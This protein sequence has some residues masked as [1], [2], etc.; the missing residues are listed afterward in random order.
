MQAKIPL[1][2]GAKQDSETCQLDMNGRHRSSCLFAGTKLLHSSNDKLMSDV[3]S[4]KNLP[5][6]PRIQGKIPALFLT[7]SSGYYSSRGSIIQSL[8]KSKTDIG[9]IL[10]LESQLDQIRLIGVLSLF[11]AGACMYLLC[12]S[13]SDSLFKQIVQV[14]KFASSLPLSQC[15]IPHFAYFIA[16]HENFSR[17]GAI[18]SADIS[19]CISTRVRSCVTRRE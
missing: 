16:V 3:S 6:L 8:I 19:I 10:S 18:R 12:S 17:S 15:R 14:N 13:R 5:A 9:A 2:V 1:D 11:A 4:F 7:L